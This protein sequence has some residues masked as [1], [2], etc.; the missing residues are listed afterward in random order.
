MNDFIIVNTGPGDD[1]AR[2]AFLASEVYIITER[3]LGSDASAPYTRVELHDG[4][5]IKAY[6]EFS[7]LVQRIRK[8]AGRGLN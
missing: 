7:D 5:F 1:A 2:E 3:P 4:R 8:G 6:E